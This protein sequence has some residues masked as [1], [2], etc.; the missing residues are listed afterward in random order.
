MTKKAKEA[1]EQAQTAWM[2]LGLIV[3]SLVL[4]AGLLWICWQIVKTVDADTVRIWAVA[5][6]LALP[7]IGIVC[8]KLGQTWAEG[9]VSGLDLGVNEVMR[10]AQKTADLRVGTVA[11]VRQSTVRQ[12][13]PA[14]SQAPPP[15]LPQPRIT[16]RAEDGAGA[17]VIDV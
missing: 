1:R 4:I 2:W 15:A 13:P 7:I 8:W 6:T 17:H 10:A 5:T 11:R 9:R 12:A 16:H 14:A 3:T